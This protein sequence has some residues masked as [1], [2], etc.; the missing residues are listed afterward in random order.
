[1]ITDRYY[2]SVQLADELLKMK[3]HL[4]GKIK[5]NRKG[6]PDSIKKP[7]FLCVVLTKQ[8]QK[9]VIRFWSNM[10]P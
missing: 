8:N 3:C 9:L 5:I 2:T 10:H 4:T 6:I 7:K 1:M